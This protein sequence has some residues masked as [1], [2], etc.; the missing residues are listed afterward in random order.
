MTAIE[1]VSRIKSILKD[2]SVLDYFLDDLERC[3]LV[4]FDFNKSINIILAARKAKI[5]I[6]GI[7]ALIEM[8]KL[9]F[10]IE[11]LNKFTKGLTCQTKSKN[12]QLS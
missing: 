7:L 6:N 1:K 8:P 11:E 3:L 10:S 5:D 12:K 2:S 9:G 4:G